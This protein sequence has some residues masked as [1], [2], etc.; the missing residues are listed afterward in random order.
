M[1]D[2]SH[3]RPFLNARWRFLAMFNWRIAPGFLQPHLPVG[4][5]LDTWHGAHYVSVVGFRFLETR[6]LGIPIP[7]IRTSKR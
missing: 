2:E 1:P 7:F 6:V 5:E 4:T 3:E